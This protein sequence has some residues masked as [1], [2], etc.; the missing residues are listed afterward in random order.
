MGDELQGVAAFID[1]LRRRDR[2]LLTASAALRVLGVAAATALVASIAVARGWDRSAAITV[3]VLLGGCGLW[4]AA[5]L[6][7]LTRWRAASDPL[8]QARLVEAMRPAL[9]GRLVVATSRREASVPGESPAMLALVARRAMAAIA[10]LSPAQVHRSRRLWRPGLIAGLGVLAA[11]CASVWVGPSRSAHWWLGDGSASAAVATPEKTTPEETAA[12]GDVVLRY[13]YPAYTGLDEHVVANSTG[14]AHGPPGTWV[15]V[16]A[17]AALP[18]EAAALVAY[19]EPA[20][21]AAVVDERTMT[22]QFIIRREA[23]TY[24]LLTYSS[25]EALPS[26][27]F[28]ITPEPDLPPE[29]ML[30]DTPPIIEVAADEIVAL[31]WRARDDYGIARVVM[32]VDAT[33][34]GSPLSAPRERRAEVFDVTQLR[35]VDLGL[36]PGDRAGIAIVAWDND[37][38]GGSK[39]GRSPTVE[40]VVLGPR[41]LHQ[42]DDERRRLLL[43]RM[44]D[45][46]AAHLTEPWPPGDSSAE[47]ARWGESLVERYAPLDD[48]VEQYAQSLPDTVD[49]ELLQ[50]VARAAR[51]L[52]RYTQVAFSPAERRAPTDAALQ[53]TGELRDAAIVQLEDAIYALDRMI[54]SRA[55]EDVAEQAERLAHTASNLEEMLAG[56]AD[57][58]EMLSRLDQ[59][60]RMLDSV[61]RTAAKLD[62]GGLKEFI[63]S[64]AQS[65]ESM[66]DEIRQAIA[67]GRMDEA[68]EL[69]QRLARDIQEMSEGLQD[70]LAGSQAEQDESMQA[71]AD[72]D[73]QLE[74][75]EKDQRDLQER[76]QQLREQSDE[77]TASEAESLWEQ[78]QRKARGVVE[79]GAKYAAGLEASNRVFNERERALDAVDESRRLE[80]AAVGR[81]VDGALRAVH[82]SRRSWRKAEGMRAFEATRRGGHLPGPGARAISEIQNELNEIEELLDKLREL[83]DAVDPETRQAV[84]DL[85]KEQ[86]ALDERLSEARQSAKELSRQMPV[87]PD[88]LE[89]SL[90]EAQDEMGRAEGS[91]EGGKPMPAEGS[92]G[93]AAQRIADARESVQQAMRQAQQMA[94]GSRGGES[95][96]GDQ[97]Q[98]SRDQG[99]DGTGDLRGMQIEI[100]G[101]EDYLV[102]EEYRR[103]LL[104]GMEG[105]V[106]EEYRALKKRYYEEL[107]QQ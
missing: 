76:V 73:A 71:A 7:L 51:E 11:L 15:E 26:R 95:Q 92:M 72:L 83:S 4:V 69:M 60:E 56:D 38:V 9:R 77:A 13:I 99:N 24:H 82:E 91:L 18:I 33:P 45:V 104:E 44:I 68:R 65:A 54:R 6:P 41:G 85:A 67:E 49:S 78:V 58:Q 39:S 12:V 1:R 34:R 32:E 87:R 98:G 47:V 57:A 14:E 66:I 22:G 42:R 46:L 20:L 19:D 62:E 93:A 48:L 103:A 75:L 80:Q 86:Q 101:P 64:R 102:P 63:N 27:S 36:G 28:P 100:P 43:E 16:S 81:D 79:D 59:L 53:T 37:T 35:P 84:Q 96:E 21:D 70:N 10:D 5:A 88:G 2:R 8:H 55:L 105:E 61:M 25:G 31:G 52:I 3:V 29:V 94:Q 74:E 17:R 23:G 97:Q 40:L 89:E 30:D 106:P 90:E 107:V 50:R